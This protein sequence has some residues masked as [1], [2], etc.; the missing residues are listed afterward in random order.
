MEKKKKTVVTGMIVCM[1]GLLLSLILPWF[2]YLDMYSVLIGTM[3]I[4][5]WNSF[6]ILV[7]GLASII[8]AWVALR[9]DE[10]KKWYWATLISGLVSFIAALLFWFMNS[11][12]SFVLDSIPRI[13]FWLMV[14][15]GLGMA[16][17][18]LWTLF[19]QNSWLKDAE[20]VEES[21][22]EGSDWN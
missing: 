7:V 8:L 6:L 19:S 16:G 9:N 15:S 4:R 1:A 10:P 13:G 20:A 12:D 2:A 11:S 21:I 14:F 18:S 22:S 5:G 17:F 3:L